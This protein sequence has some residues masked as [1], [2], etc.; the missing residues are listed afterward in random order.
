MFGIKMKMGVMNR[1]GIFFS[2]DALIAMFLIFIV[3]I[4]AFPE[5]EDGSYETEV[6][7]DILNT[8]SLLKVGDVNDAYVQSLIASGEITNLDK[9]LLEQIGEFYV[10]DIPKAR[11]VADSVLSNLNFSENV[12]IWYGATLIYSSNSTPIENSTNV[13]VS[14][15]ILSGIE[16]GGNVTGFSAR[17]FL[18]SD[19]LSEYYYF[20]GY[21]GDG[22][23]S[24]SVP[25]TGNISTARL[26]IVANKDF[27][28]Y[29]NGILEGTY[30]GSPDEFTPV[31]YTLSVNNFVSG[32]NTVG[33][34][35]DNLHVA[36]GFLRIT[37]KAS[38]SFS[39]S[40]KYRFPGIDGLI[41][42]YDGFYIPGSLI[43]MNVYLH[44]NSSVTPT[45]LNIGNVTVYNS[46]TNDEEM[47]TINDATL[48]SLLDYGDLSGNTI[49][50]RLGLDNVSYTGVVQD[51]D[52][53]S[54]TDLSGSM[55]P[56]CSGAGF[57]CCLF[58]GDFC[59]SEPTCNS[60]SGTWEDKLGLAKQGNDVFIDA[61]LNYSGNR[62][63]LVGYANDATAGYHVLSNDNVSL[64]NEVA[65]WTAT[66]STC[67]CCGINRASSDLVSYSGPEKFQSMVVMSDGE[68][69]VQC[70]QQG[71]G[72]AKDDAIQAACDAK[73]DNITVHAVGFGSG[74]DEAT[75]QAIA[76][77]GN[78]TYFYSDI[79]ELADIYQQ[80]AGSII[81]EY[82]EQT[83]GVVGDLNTKL[84]DDSYVEFDYVNGSFPLGLI[85]TLENDF[86]GSYGGMFSVPD[87]ATVV[88]TRVTSY[89]GPRWTD[90]L[91]I[92]GADV[93]K[94]SNYGEDY[95]SLGDPY[96]V[97]IPNALVVPGSSNVVN[98][99]TGVSPTNS[100]AGSTYNKVLLT[101]VK[102]ASAF[103]EIKVSANGCFWTVEFEDGSFAMANIPE[104][105]SGSDVCFYDSITMGQIDNPN[106][107]LQVAVLNLLKELDIDS[108]GRV[109]FLF[110][111]EE[112]Q[113]SLN[114]VTGIPFTWTTEVQSRRWF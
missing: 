23:L 21:I 38:A 100:S 58:S 4:V 18:I 36:G 9:S 42:L 3:L 85:L 20:G 12:G 89:S 73:N 71:T 74:A 8:L 88:E 53:Y 105:Y 6:H 7:Q 111:E 22:N 77:C 1:R 66:G 45:F 16:E 112:L 57:W 91:K 54:V 10:T 76:Q 81:A 52:V 56:S 104:T 113:V 102:N 62:V 48:S 5:K 75:L 26:E 46:T 25:Y 37:Y 96:I 83:L 55:A 35:G 79:E 34:R 31:N 33:F 80:I 47:I 13:D 68:A 14:R 43:S 95:V 39:Q 64:K 40:T 63:G 50:L 108:D 27:D 114:Q 51:V 44:M 41:N 15:H 49:P 19:M 106:D 2:G 110:N 93:Y 98:L 70:A 101:I 109:D 97:N 82:V 86:S 87:E 103:S 92:N 84:F 29:V 61:I 78:G 32:D 94:L 99:T 107:A 30:S 17:A 72:D 69:N 90:N 67:I 28:L 65:S 11:A 24:I 60:C 59:G